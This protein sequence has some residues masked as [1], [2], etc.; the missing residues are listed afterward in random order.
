[1]TAPGT[2]IGR[3][4]VLF[5]ALFAITLNAFQ[6]LAHAVAMRVAWNGEIGADGSAARTLW[7]VLCQVVDET[8]ADTGMP[9][10]SA[11]RAHECCLGFP[12]IWT[13]VDDGRLG[14]RIDRILSEARIPVV[15]HYH[16]SSGIRGDPLQPRAPPFLD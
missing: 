4:T 16:S 9:A 10:P 15:P 13:L 11:G 12:N 2:S 14:A 1:M 6:P 8:D 7:P 3:A 5:A